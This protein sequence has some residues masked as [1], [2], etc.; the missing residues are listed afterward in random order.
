MTD[1]PIMD[2]IST[3]FEIVDDVILGARGLLKEL[4]DLED[5]LDL[6]TAVQSA[7]SVLEDAIERLDTHDE[8]RAD[9]DE[10]DAVCHACGGDGCQY[11]DARY[12]PSEDF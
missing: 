12:L 5:P 10:D 11:C 6:P 3:W 7:L 9:N 4:D 2:E 8:P 1:G